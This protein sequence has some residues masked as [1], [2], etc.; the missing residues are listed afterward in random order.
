MSFA[1]FH[2]PTSILPRDS[3]KVAPGSV[4]LLSQQSTISVANRVPFGSILLAFCHTLRRLVGLQLVNLLNPLE[5]IDL[6]DRFVVPDAQNSR[7]TQRKS[8]RMPVRTHDVI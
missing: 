7:K 6:V 3:H 8:T 2:S 4:M 1:S 5:S